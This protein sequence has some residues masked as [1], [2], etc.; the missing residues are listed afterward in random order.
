MVPHAQRYRGDPIA[1]GL[2][3]SGAA[4]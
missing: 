4:V 2:W 3:V 1:K